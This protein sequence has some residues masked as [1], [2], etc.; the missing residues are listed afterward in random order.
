VNKGGATLY[1]IYFFSKEVGTPD[2]GVF[3]YRGGGGCDRKF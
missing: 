2:G 1:V 3:L